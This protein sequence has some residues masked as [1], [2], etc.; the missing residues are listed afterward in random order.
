[1]AKKLRR[2]RHPPVEASQEQMALNANFVMQLPT[3]LCLR[4]GHKWTPRKHGR[5]GVCPQCHSGNWAEP[6]RPVS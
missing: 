5:P 2:R 1:M 4:C 6:L 3:L